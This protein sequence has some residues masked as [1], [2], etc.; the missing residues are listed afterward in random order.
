MVEK[1][2]RLMRCSFITFQPCKFTFVRVMVSQPQATC[3]TTLDLF[4]VS[5]A[6]KEDLKI[7][8]N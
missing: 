2:L 7:L 1:S 5:A 8:K 3:L 6:L 4:E